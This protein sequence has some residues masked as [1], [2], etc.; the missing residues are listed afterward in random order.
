MTKATTKAQKKSLAKIILKLDIIN[1]C[2][3]WFYKEFCRS[4]NVWPWTFVETDLW[5]IFKHTYLGLQ[6]QEMKT[7]FIKSIYQG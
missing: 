6:F 4:D 2:H 5:I 3:F 1:Y 7:L